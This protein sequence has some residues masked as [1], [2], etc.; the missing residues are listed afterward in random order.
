MFKMSV[1]VVGIV[2]WL[3]VVLSVGCWWDCPLVV[4]GGIVTCYRG[5]IVSWLLVGTDFISPSLSLQSADATLSS[6]SLFPILIPH[7][8]QNIIPLLA[9]SL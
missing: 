9:S 1:V 3:L 5:G 4:G 8:H 2:R 6:N 7:F